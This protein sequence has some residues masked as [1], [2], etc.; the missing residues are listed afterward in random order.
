MLKPR[1]LSETTTA[2]GDRKR[3]PPPWAA[4]FS[5]HRFASKVSLFEET[6][7]E[8]IL[9]QET[10]FTS[11]A[12]FASFSK[13]WASIKDFLK[14]QASHPQPCSQVFQRFSH[15][16]KTFQRN[17]PQSF[18]LAA[19]KSQ[20]SMTKAMPFEGVSSMQQTNRKEA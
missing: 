11:S 9:F 7:F 10:G 2:Q 1:L 16:S 13:I 18:E 5:K 17:K 12:F 6:S 19:N 3:D 8:Q 4:R 20:R 14:K 15:P